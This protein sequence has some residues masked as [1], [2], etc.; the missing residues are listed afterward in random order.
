M[1]S[2]LVIVS[3][4]LVSIGFGKAPTPVKSQPNVLIDIPVEDSD[5]PSIFELIQ[6]LK[7][8]MSG[9]G[10]D[11][12]VAEILALVPMEQESK[13]ALAK[14]YPERFVPA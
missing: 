11:V 1:R 10:D 12:T 9:S 4:I 6:T 13:N 5:G 8:V 2:I 3:L 14:A 7:G